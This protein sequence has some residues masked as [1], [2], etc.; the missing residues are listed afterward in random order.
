MKKILTIAL[1]LPFVLV[2]AQQSL[3]IN[4]ITGSQSVFESVASGTGTPL[5][6]EDIQGSPYQSPLFQKASVGEKY[7]NIEVRYNAY[8]DDME[9]LNNGKTEVLPKQDDF[10]RIEVLSSKQAFVYFKNSTEPKGYLIEI[11]KGKNS[12]YKKEKTIFKDAA[13]AANTYQTG[14]PAMFVKQD[15]VYYIK[16]ASGITSKVSSLK[17]ITDLFP[18]KEKEYN[19]YIKSNNLKFNDADIVKLTAF[20]NQ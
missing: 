18:E 6:Y 15:P 1:F 4:N 11:A 3:N 7:G 19:A 14:K 8:T 20:I 16:T 13:A 2:N 9:F 17:K 10:S 12:V 5:R